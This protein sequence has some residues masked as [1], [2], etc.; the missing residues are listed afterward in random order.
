MGR[1]PE[2]A[3][4]TRLLARH[5]LV[6]VTGPGG[7]GKTRLAVEAA[8]R[9]TD[10]FPDGVRLVELAPVRGSTQ[11][12]GH[13]MRVLGVRDRQGASSAELLAG[14]LAPRRMLLVL[15]NCEHVLDAVAELCGFL[16]LAAD[17]LRV[18]A[19]SR[20]QLWVDGEARYRLSP[21]GL[22]VSGDDPAAASQSEAVALFA[23]RARGADPRFS[24]DQAN[25]A[26]V[27]R[28]VERLDGMPLAIELAAARVEALGLGGLA[29]VTDDVVRLLAGPDRAA[30]GR[31]RSLAAVADWS[32][33]LLGEEER[34]V[35]RRLAVFPGLFTLEAAQAVA[36]PGTGP[37]VLR[38]V[39]C[40]LLVPPRPGA[41]GRMRYT[42]LETLRAFGMDRLAEAGEAPGAMATLCR[43]AV[44]VAEAAAAGLE[45]TDREAEA[46][47]RLDT[48]DATLAAALAWAADHDPAAALRL[49]A[50]LASWWRLRG[51]LN[52]AR[53]RLEAALGHASPASEGWAA[54][55]L[56]FGHV[57]YTIGDHARMIACFNAVCE[58]G[59]GTE[60]S[61]WAVDALLARS[62]TKLNEGDFAAARADA[63]RALALARDICPE[64]EAP[65]LAM[66]GGYAILTGHSALA[67]DFVRRARETL[68]ASTPGTIARWCRQKFAMVLID[69]GE[70]D[71]ARREYAAGMALAREVGDLRTIASLLMIKT[72]LELLAGNIADAGEGLRQAAPM[73]AQIADYLN[74]R[75]CVYLGGYLCAATGRWT[76]TVTLWAA[77]DADA[78]SRGLANPDEDVYR[79][80]RS[81]YTGQIE[82]ALSPAQI[83]EARQRGASMLVPAAIEYIGML[84]EPDSPGPRGAAETAEPADENL[85][86]RERELVTLVA[87]GSTNAQIAAR[88]YISVHTVR[89]HLDRIRDKTGCRRRADLTRLALRQGLVLA[90]GV[91]GGEVWSVVL[92]ADGQVDDLRPG[93]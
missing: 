67:V 7:V 75:N 13:L 48:E 43:L 1:E 85:S 61:R 12:A 2:I 84:T 4:I 39:D 6:T 53:A 59:N 86:P 50:A 24:L 23:E 31:H 11:V 28:V 17:D 73:A 3:D 80:R 66:L 79:P 51:R 60:R 21:L 33:Q 54:A 27:S 46:L 30:G 40:S 65:A 42:M 22:P 44:S 38:L 49:A 78:A 37:V 87:Q 25:A 82:R 52:E 55:Q 56:A 8:G 16:L 64:W 45:T 29:G 63:G 72:R 71:W 91:V 41:D 5:R 77:A 34:R 92:V 18:L 69:V 68:S 81:E 88:L 10:R 70:F 62:L 36:G 93:G 20:E 35:L 47:R 32:Y 57:L 89:S 19:T 74:M 14:A 9:V 83:Q 15:D 90:G 58:P 26:D 76:E